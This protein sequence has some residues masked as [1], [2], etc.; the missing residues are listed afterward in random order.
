MVDNKLIPSVDKRISAWVEYQKSSANKKNP[1]KQKSFSITISREYGCEGYPLAEE[2]RNILQNNGEHWTVFDELLLDKIQENH[3]ISKNLL[4][5]F[6]QQSTFMDNLIAMLVPNWDTEEQAYRF[7]A[8]TIHTIA[9]KG[10]AII[11][12]RGASVITREIKDCYHFRLV[13]PLKFRAKSIAERAEISISK[14]EDEILNNQQKRDSFINKFLKSDLSDS[15]YYHLI[16]NNSKINVNT[17]AKTILE[18]IKIN[19]EI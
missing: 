8:E 19:R 7:I 9:S 16:F 5:G 4:K 12:G 1:D 3:E 6:G 2:L 13:A 15:N 14:A 18:F 10:N 11:V 17:I